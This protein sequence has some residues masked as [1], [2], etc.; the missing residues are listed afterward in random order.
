MKKILIIGGNSGIGEALAIKLMDGEYEVHLAL[1]SAEKLSPQLEASV[2][3]VQN[4][5]AGENTELTLPDSLDGIVYCPG[6]INLKPFHRFT[7]DDIKNDM[8][9]NLYGAVGVIQQALPAL[10]KSGHSS[11]VLFSSVAA[12]TGLGMHASIAMAKGAVEGLTTALAAEFA[13]SK[14][15]VNAI[16]PSLTDTP[17]AEFI[18]GSESRKSAASEKHPLKRIGDPNDVA[19]LIEYLLSDS[20]GFIT[21]QIFKI[22]GGLSSIR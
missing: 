22:D 6:T 2:A 17:L 11:I 14:I 16:A 15:R 12:Q 9:V 3:S 19:T 21:G 18:V 5:L 8:E 1:R 4:F 13:P 10:K 7:L 20:A